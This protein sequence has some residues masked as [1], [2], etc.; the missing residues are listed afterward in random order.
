VRKQTA[1]TQQIATS[2]SGQ[3]LCRT[4]HIIHL[5]TARM[6][7][8]VQLPNNVFIPVHIKDVKMVIILPV[9]DRP[10]R[11]ITAMKINTATQQQVQLTAD[12]RLV[13]TEQF[14]PEPQQPFINGA[15]QINVPMV[16]THNQDIGTII[17]IIIATSRNIK[18]R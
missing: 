11:H 14:V 15:V 1:I 7:R 4:K 17:H 10:L 2:A 5:T 18:M 16:Q 6:G 13:R 8:Y 9:A 12:K 3:T